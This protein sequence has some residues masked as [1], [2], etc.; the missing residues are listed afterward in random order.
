VLAAR[1]AFVKKQPTLDAS[2]LVFL[3]ECAISTALNHRYGRSKRG[4]RVVLHAPTYG[5]RRTL[6]GA[7]ALDGRRTMTT[8]KKGLRTD[9]YLD[10]V[11]D[12]LVPMLRAGDTVIMDNLRIHHN[13]DAIALIEE[14]GATVVFQPPYSPEF[15]AIEFCWSWLKHDL[16]RAAHRRIEPLLASV[17]ERW[18]QVTPTLCRSWAR[19]CGYAV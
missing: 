19:G 9:T 8:L 3:D 14:A 2:R 5:T 15:N 13:A 18:S 1:E 10:F 12:H 4:K 16:R 11:R 7:I 6:V 17:K